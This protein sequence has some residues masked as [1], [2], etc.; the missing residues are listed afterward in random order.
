MR[1]NS[2]AYHIIMISVDQNASLALWLY[3]IYYVIKFLLEQCSKQTET[4]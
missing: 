4:F 1:L 3:Y 2:Y